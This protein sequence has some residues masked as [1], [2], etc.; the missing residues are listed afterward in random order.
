M[1]CDSTRDV[2]K[3]WGEPSFRPGRAYLPQ[4]DYNDAH[5]VDCDKQYAS[6]MYLHEWRWPQFSLMDEPEL[7]DLSEGVVPGF[8][9]V[10]DFEEPDD[11][12]WEGPGA[13][14]HSWVDYHLN[15]T[16]ILRPSDVTE[17]VRATSSFDA[18]IFKPTVR[19]LFSHGP[20]IGKS[21]CCLAVGLMDIGEPRSVSNHMMT[22]DLQELQHS[23][24]AA[25]GL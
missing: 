15:E 12:S 8:Y 14:P 13:Y 22:P 18:D 17:M 21:A 2:L 4:E 7:C 1:F 20:D 9:H 3:G 10:V 24:L 25:D 23:R 6:C 5:G 19:E 16:G 11:P